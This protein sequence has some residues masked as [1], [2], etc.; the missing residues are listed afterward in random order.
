MN[1]KA[2]KTILT[3]LSVVL[4]IY[5]VFF[6]GGEREDAPGVLVEETAVYK[7]YADGELYTLRIYSIA[8][9]RLREDGPMNKRPTVTEEETNLWSV[10]LQA[11]TG[12]DARWTYY[13]APLEGR[14]SQ[15]R[16]G[17]FDQRNGLL[18][19]LN[20]EN[21]SLVVESIF[22]GEPYWELRDFSQPLAATAEAPF[23][24]AAFVDD[25]RS[26]KVT[27]LSGEDLHE[28]TEVVPL[29]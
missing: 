7:L 11:G 20:G 24:N 19:R 6:R 1:Q 4:A 9:E 23:T 16:Y 18:V 26:V 25:G 13:F 14:I 12:V 27:Y 17:V 10:S 5:L 29:A 28:V 21:G 15:T 3:I 2:L 8:G 22:D